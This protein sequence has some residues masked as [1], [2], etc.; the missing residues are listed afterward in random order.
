M[1]RVLISGAGGYIG[2]N[3][4]AAMRGVADVV[5]L[6]FKPGYVHPKELQN[7]GGPFDVFFNL[8]WEG[9][10]GPMRANYSIQTANVK[11]ALDF[12]RAAVRLGCR[13]YI[14]AGTVGELMVELPECA[15]IHSQNFVYLCAK[16]FL[17]RVLNAIEEPEICPV[18][19]ARIGN[20]YGGGDSGGNLV[21]FTLSRIAHGE[22]AEF[23][24]AVQPYDFVHANDAV[25]ALALIGLSDG[26]LPGELYVGSGEVR[27]LRDYLVE[28]GQISGRP[29][30]IEIGGR[31]DDGTRYRA[32]WFSID[33]LSRATG[34]VPH[35]PFAEG[36]R[37]MWEEMRQ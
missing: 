9:K 2:R 31:P 28:I 27:V 15:H 6:D 29:E 37:E 8:A 22:K 11:S 26:E 33:P 10:G 7:L 34:F 19:W 18:T 1:K 17:H 30:L 20:L 35:I 3:L 16:N 25:R 12:Y 24:P 36:V 5:G 23:G 14:C 32:E 13:R 4:S 21:Q